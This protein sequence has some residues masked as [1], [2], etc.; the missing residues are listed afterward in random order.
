VPRGETNVFA[1]HLGAFQFVVIRMDC[2]QV[3]HGPNTER[4]KAAHA[5]GRGLRAA[6][7]I[8]DDFVKICRTFDC[9]RLG[10]SW[11]GDR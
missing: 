8:I 11:R 10:P 9:N 6:V 1:L 3:N 7:E 2:A 5:F 4:L